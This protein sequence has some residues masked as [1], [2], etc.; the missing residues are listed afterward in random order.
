MEESRR[1]AFEVPGGPGAREG[2]EYRTGAESEALF[3][4]DL[5]RIIAALRRNVWWIA[6]IVIACLVLGAV[7]TMLIVPRYIASA[8]VLIE[9]ETDQIIAVSYTHLTLPTNREV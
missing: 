4:V 5:H 6:G 9:Q 7:I 8:T 3:E 2:Y 1:P